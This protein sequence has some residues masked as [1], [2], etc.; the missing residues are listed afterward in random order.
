MLSQV[1]DMFC[2]PRTGD[3][4]DEFSLNKEKVSRSVSYDANLLIFNDAIF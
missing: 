2:D 1:F 4:E 3:T